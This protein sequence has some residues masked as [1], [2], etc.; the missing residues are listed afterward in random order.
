MA[1]RTRSKAEIGGTRIH[2]GP[3]DLP[4]DQLLPFRKELVLWSDPT[5]RT[6]GDAYISRK[7]ITDDQLSVK[8]RYNYVRHYKEEAGWNEINF[9]YLMSPPCPPLFIRMRMPVTAYPNFARTEKYNWSSALSALATDV[10]SRMDSDFQ[11]AVFLKELRESVTM[12]RNPFN[13]FKRH[14]LRRLPKGLTAEVGSRSR[15]L[16]S[17][18]LEYRYGWRLLLADVENF[19]KALVSASNSGTLQ[20]GLTNWVR[21]SQ[22]AEVDSIPISDQSTLGVIGSQSQFDAA[23]NADEP[24]RTNVVGKMCYARLRNYNHEYFGIVSLEHMRPFHST[25]KLFQKI[26]DVLSISNWRQVRDTL[27]E[28]MPLSFVV[29][30]FVNFSDIWR[31]FDA[32]RLSKLD[33]RRV[34]YSVNK[35]Y[36]TLLEIV[37]TKPNYLVSLGEPY[38]SGIITDQRGGRGI[39]GGYPG[40]VAYYARTPGLPLDGTGIFA[41]EGLS[42]FQ[43]LDILSI[44]NQLRP[45]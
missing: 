34:G 21:F 9:S 2:Y 43:T 1:Y 41:T 33:C 37:L 20:R 10:S 24:W 7:Q 32:I 12:I 39:Q 18:W 15:E 14:K 6:Y 25:A 16:S 26:L 4:A 44:C 23:A 36:N 40:K 35:T 30:W 19:A 8:T 38:A 3:Q 45:K 42:L 29:D 17:Y 5:Y 31:P 22:K 13:L 28:I 11:G 27:W